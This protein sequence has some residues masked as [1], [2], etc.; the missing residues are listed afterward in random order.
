MKNYVQ[1]GEHVT[2]VAEAAVKAGTL[3]RIG[4][5]TGVAQ[6]DAVAGE[7]VTLVR[8]GVFELAKT[9]AQAWTPGA[10]VYLAAGGGDL[11]TTASGNTLV[12]VTLAA[13]A[14]PSDTGLVL[15]DG[16]IR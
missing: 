2:L 13:A 15:L 10:K 6:E 11:T 7:N 9:S 1:P 16:V 5:I 3:V 8:R 14:D 12:G 4:A